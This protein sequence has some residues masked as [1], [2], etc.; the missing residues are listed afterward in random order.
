MV[1]RCGET[2]HLFLR[3]EPAASLAASATLALL[4][5]VDG[6][7]VRSDGLAAASAAQGLRDAAPCAG[8]TE[9][10]ERW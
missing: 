6:G 4:N 1:S 7:Y 9:A 2:H 10:A 8:E 3:K 5:A